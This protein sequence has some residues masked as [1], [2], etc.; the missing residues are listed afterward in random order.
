MY[1]AKH[2]KSIMVY[3]YTFAIQ[4]SLLVIRVLYNMA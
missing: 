2:I 4:Y 3:I 1:G